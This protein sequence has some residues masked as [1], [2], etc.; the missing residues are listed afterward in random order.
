MRVRT[1]LLAGAWLW[2]QQLVR[3]SERAMG[4]GRKATGELRPP[5]GLPRLRCFSS[6]LIRR[7]LSKL[8]DTGLAI[9]SQEL[10]RPAR[11]VH[12]PGAENDCAAKNKGDRRD[13]G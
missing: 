3:P 10:L 7:S 13:R 11:M 6:C 9:S 2:R 5:Y 4:S 8:L 12:N 1:W